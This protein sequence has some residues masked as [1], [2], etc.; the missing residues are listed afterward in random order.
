VAELAPH[1]CAL[2]PDPEAPGRLRELQAA[3][4]DRRAA[5]GP[6]V[7]WR[8]AGLSYGRAA[9]TLQVTG[10]GGLSLAAEH[11]VAILLAVDRRLTR[12]I[13]RDALAP[14]DVLKPGPR[15]RLTRTLEAWLRGRG[16]TE[17]VAGML[18][19]HPQTVRYRMARV[20]EL[21]GDRLD[22]PEARFELELA[23][24]SPSGR[25]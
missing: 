4:R 25:E 12:D 11:K 15:E 22:D 10:V 3:L 9:A 19:V 6:V 5:L 14:L 20:R 21:L 24:R 17:E 16:R 18:H 8:E 13:A 2:I 7:D 1:I 23:L